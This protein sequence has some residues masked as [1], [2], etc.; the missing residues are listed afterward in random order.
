MRISAHVMCNHA[1][2]PVPIPAAT[3]PTCKHRHTQTHRQTDA[4]ACAHA[5]AYKHVRAHTR[6]RTHT[7]TAS[8]NI[9]KTGHTENAR[10]TALS[11]SSPKPSLYLQIVSDGIL[12]PRLYLHISANGIPD[13]PHIISN[14]TPDFRT[15]TPHRQQQHTVRQHGTPDDQSA[16]C[17]YT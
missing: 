17:S 8:P 6:A 12:N 14:S 10:S 2:L 3:V 7:V 4:H 11:N 13:P 16:K 15:L 5:R 1:L 9:L